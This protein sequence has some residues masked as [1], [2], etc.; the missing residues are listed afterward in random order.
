MITTLKKIS[1]ITASNGNSFQ[2]LKSTIHTCNRLLA[3]KLWRMSVGLPK[4]Q[5]ARGSITDLPDYSF[6]GKSLNS[7]L[8][9]CVVE[10]F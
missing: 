7:I 6:I 1:P 2:V 4:L 8:I 10:V 5:T 3:G 9:F